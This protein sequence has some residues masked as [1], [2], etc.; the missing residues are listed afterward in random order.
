MAIMV[1]SG[2][3]PCIHRIC[4]APDPGELRGEFALEEGV[5]G[6]GRWFGERARAETLY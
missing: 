4:L 5:G 6:G 1:I 3:E 2:A